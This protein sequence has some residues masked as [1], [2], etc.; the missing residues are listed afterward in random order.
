MASPL[1]L[2]Q[3]L[4]VDGFQHCAYPVTGLLEDGRWFRCQYIGVLWS[5]IE[6]VAFEGL[7]YA[8][9]RCQLYASEFTW[10]AT[11]DYLLHVTKQFAEQ[12]GHYQSCKVTRS[13]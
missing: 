4:Q 12:K 5:V 13:G 10:Q 3:P 7:E 9:P 6:V 11:I 1:S 2:R 8:L